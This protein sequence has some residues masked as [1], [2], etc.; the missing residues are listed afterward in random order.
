M[1]DSLEIGLAMI[2][3]PP[4]PDSLAKFKVQIVRDLNDFQRIVTL[5]AVVFMSE[6]LCPFDEE[7]DG[8][9]L[10]ATHLLVRDG[11]QDVATLRIRWFANFGKIERVCILP[12]YRGTDVVR[13][14]LAHTFE[15]AARKG[16][17]LMLAQ[18]QA[19]LSGVWSHVLVGEVRE[20]RP[21]FSFSDFDYQEMEFRLPPHPRALRDDAD[22][23]VIIRPEGDWDRAGILERSLTRV[24]LKVASN[25]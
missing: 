7:F 13:I 23:Y 14:L 8:N 4:T 17:R 5:R 15:F 19:R 1:M 16:Y 10:T 25:G 11:E 20:N 6:Q 22:P 9:D 3:R 18:I 24:P 21:A 12:A 2:R